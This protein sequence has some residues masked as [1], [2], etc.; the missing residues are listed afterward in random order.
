MADTI[1][2]VIGVLLAFALLVIAPLTITRMTED[3]A[4]KRLI[5][6]EVTQ[7]IDKVTDKGSVSASDMDDLMIGV[8]SYG[9][10][11]NV[12]VTRYI[13]VAV[14]DNVSGAVKT[15][16]VVSDDN[17]N[18]LSG[19]GMVYLEPGDAVQV[20]VEGISLTKGQSFIR[21]VLRVYE[22]QFEFTL[23]GIVR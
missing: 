10:T 5:L 2:K 8:N 11:F 7:F 20:R 23:A 16:Y 6:N 17:I 12:M 4:A 9:G 14:R 21:A 13:P 15:T 19:S 3:M 1:S 18:S 22:R